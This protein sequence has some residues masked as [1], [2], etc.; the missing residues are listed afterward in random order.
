MNAK[1]IVLGAMTIGIC[2]CKTGAHDDA[3]ETENRS[4]QPA[5][6]Q[7]TFSVDKADL[8][9][10]GNNRYLPVHPGRAIK[11]TNGNDTLT[12]TILNETEMVDGVKVG[13]LEERETKNGALEEISRNFLATDKQT[14]DVYYFGEDVDV[15]KDGKVAN[16]ESEWRAGRNGARFGMMIPA[17]PRVGQKFYQEFAPKIAMDRIEIVSTDET[18]KTPAGTF[19]HCVHFKETTP[20][21]S[22]VSHKYFAP[23]IGMIKDDDFELAEKP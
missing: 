21:E 3:S 13:I 14:G 22:E 11:M 4:A 1:W 18:V 20:I 16:H 8:E 6:W 10:T 17:H 2:G 7:E 19:R 12:V 15:Y 9:P 23:G 5:G